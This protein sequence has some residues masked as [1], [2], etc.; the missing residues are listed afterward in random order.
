MAASK[1]EIH[2]PIIESI[3]LGDWQFSSQKS[4][5]LN[6]KCTD[7]FRCDAVPAV[8]T[9]A[10][11]RRLYCDH[12][13]FEKLLE[14]P[15]LPEMCFAQ[16]ILVIEHCSGVKICFTAFDA[17]RLV[18]PHDD[19]L[20]VQMA[21]KWKE[22][23]VDSK[24]IW[25][26]VHP[27]DWT[28]TT[29]YAGTLVPSSHDFIRV[30]PTKEQINLD[31][32]KQQDKILFYNEIVLFEDELADNGVSILNV[33]IRVMTSCFFIL[34]RQFLRVDGVLIRV[35][36]TRVYHEIGTQC[37]LREISSREGATKDIHPTLHTQQ[38][39]VA[40]LLPVKYQRMEKLTLPLV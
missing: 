25:D 12:C 20:K 22:E 3:D 26:V 7:Q 17:L 34:L 2:E 35:N 9:D 32:L 30:E 36:E 40:R 8:A 19:K 4:H 6:S 14:L 18:D 27:F 37:L 39:E 29:E 38:D 10:D 21:E 31:K 16:N 33:K 24:G 13:C 11:K 5:I 15:E 28:Y 1:T 23:R